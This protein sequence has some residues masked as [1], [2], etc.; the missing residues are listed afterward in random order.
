MPTT[1]APTLIPHCLPNSFIE[2]VHPNGTPACSN[3]AVNLSCSALSASWASIARANVRC[4][5]ARM[6]CLVP[7][8]HACVSSICCIFIKL[9]K[10]APRRTLEYFSKTKLACQRSFLA[11]SLVFLGV[12]V[13]HLGECYA[14]I[15]KILWHLR[16]DGC[17]EPIHPSYIPILILK[18]C[19]GR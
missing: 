17:L 6:T 3:A 4:S 18:R 1:A 7:I 19:K 10:N 14:G 15:H 2:A 11:V 16:I 5:K 13:H 12:A 8:T 9:P